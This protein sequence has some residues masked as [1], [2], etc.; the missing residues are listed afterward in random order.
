MTAPDHGYRDVTEVVAGFDL[1]EFME[2]NQI[3]MPF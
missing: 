2:R 1:K 3:P